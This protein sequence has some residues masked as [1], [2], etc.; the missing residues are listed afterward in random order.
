MTRS[1][2]EYSIR[3]IVDTEGRTSYV[4]K[5]RNSGFQSAA[6]SPPVALKGLVDHLAPKVSQISVQAISALSGCQG[7]GG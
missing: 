5:D 6:S 7:C 2:V 1:S 3:S 4:V